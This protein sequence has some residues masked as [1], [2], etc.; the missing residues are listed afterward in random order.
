MCLAS[1]VKSFLPDDNDDYKDDICIALYVYTAL[2]ESH[3][4]RAVV[5]ILSMQMK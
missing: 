5:I 1:L 4:L 2:H 3:N